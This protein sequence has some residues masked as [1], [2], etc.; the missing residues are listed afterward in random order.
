MKKLRRTLRAV[1]SF[2]LTLSMLLTIC[3]MSGV[4]MIY[5][6]IAE[7]EIASY[8]ITEAEKIELDSYATKIEDFV[9]PLFGK[10]QISSCEYMYNLDESADYIC[11]EFETGG[12]VIYVKETMEMMEYNLQGRLPYDAAAKKYYAGPSNY[13]QKANSQFYDTITGARLSFLKSKCKL[14]HRKQEKK[15]LTKLLPNM[16]LLQ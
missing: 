5:A 3:S 13:L 9:E 6:A 7:E 16:M 11:V 10:R 1:I 4:S 14:L 2:V 12:Y 8:N 15:L